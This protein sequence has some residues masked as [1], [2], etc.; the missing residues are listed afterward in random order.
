MLRHEDLWVLCLVWGATNLRV[1][2]IHPTEISHGIIAA[3]SVEVW[4]S[5]NELLRSDGLDAARATPDRI[6]WP[7]MRT[8]R[9]DSKIEPNAK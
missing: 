2:P 9:Y 5:L 6:Y 7:A 3:L 1:P 4:T 8:R